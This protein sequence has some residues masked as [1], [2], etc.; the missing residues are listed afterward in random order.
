MSL[1]DAGAKEQPSE[2]RPGSKD[3]DSNVPGGARFTV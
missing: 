3:W 2:K 1:L